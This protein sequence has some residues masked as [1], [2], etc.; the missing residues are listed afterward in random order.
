MSRCV[1][2]AVPQM[3]SVDLGNDDRHFG[4]D[5]ARLQVTVVTVLG[6]LP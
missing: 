1:S 4:G 6:T 2:A 5:G 3:P